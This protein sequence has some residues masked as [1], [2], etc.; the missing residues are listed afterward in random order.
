[1][2]PILIRP[3]REQFEHDRIIRILQAR[4]RLTFDVEA[5][6]GDDHKA[7]LRIGQRIHYPDLVLTARGAPR[8]VQGVIEVETGE[9]VNYL[10]AMAQW[11]HFGRSKA[12]FQL[13]VPVGNVDVTKRLIGDHAIAVSE[14]WSYAHAGDSVHFWLVQ[15]SGDAGSPAVGTQIVAPIDGGYVAPAA[16][17]APTAPEPPA[18]AVAPKAV[19]APKAATGAPQPK[20]KAA[21]PAPPVAPKVKAPSGQASKGPARGAPKAPTKGVQAPRKAKAAGPVRPA[22]AARAPKAIARPKA[23]A[24]AAKKPA[25]RKAPAKPVART[26]VKRAGT[27]KPAARSA[28]K[29]ARRR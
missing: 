18:V 29:G 3:V 10:E 24:G 17:A 7:S 21:T 2:S 1:M 28:G 9:S 27:A 25:A 12:L 4:F 6:L 22:K 15:S 13:Y 26:A 8:K 11:A 23:P 5:N 20:G 19:A 14:L 16:P